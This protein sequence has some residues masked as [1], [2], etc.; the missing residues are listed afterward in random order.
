MFEDV[1]L[2]SQ[3]HRQQYPEILGIM[4]AGSAGLVPDTVALVPNPRGAKMHMEGKP[5]SKFQKPLEDL[6]L[7]DPIPVLVYQ[8]A[9]LPK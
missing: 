1:S 4:V 8:R 7:I 2:F 3:L 5:T 6:H 9:T